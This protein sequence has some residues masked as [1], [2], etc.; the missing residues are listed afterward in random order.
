MEEKGLKEEIKELKEVMK[1]QKKSKSFRMPLRARLSKHRLKRGYIIVQKISENK[2]IEFTKEPIIDGTIKL[3]DTFHAIEDY[4]LFFY[5]NKPM[6]IQPKHKLNPWNPIKSENET[7]G[8]KYIM[9]R[10][11]SDQIKLSGKKISGI[12]IFGLIIAAIIGY[13]L[14]TGGS[15]S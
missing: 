1:E 12:V 2:G 10:M 8:Q 3:H 5:K 9:A 6:I 4:D 13:Y 15:F 11:K 14:I 7:Y